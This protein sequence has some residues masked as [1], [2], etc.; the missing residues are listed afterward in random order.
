MPTPPFV[1]IQVQIN[2]G[3]QQSGGLTVAHS[4][5]VDVSITNT[6]GI[7]KVRY[8]IYD[9]PAGFGTPSGW[10]LDGTTGIIYV[11][12][13]GGAAPQFSMP[14]STTLWGDYMIRG[15]GN[16]GDGRGS[17]P[18]A[19]LTDEATALRIVSPSGLKD[20]AFKATNQFD[21][22]REWIGAFKDDLR[23]MEALLVGGSGQYKTSVKL[24]TTVNITLSGEQ[25]LDGTL[26]STSRV[27]VKDQST[28][29]QNGLYT[30]S[31]GAWT[32]T[33]DADEDSEVIAG[34]L[35]HVSEGS[36][37]NE[38]WWFVTSN[39]PI[40]V[41]TDPIVFAEI[42]TVANIGW[43]ETLAVTST[44]GGLGN[45]PTI[46]NG[47]SLLFA[48]DNAAPLIKQSD[49]TSGAGVAMTIQAQTTTAIDV[50]GAD[51]VLEV[52]DTGGGTGVQGNVIFGV[53]GGT[54][55]ARISIGSAS[56]YGPGLVFN[57]NIVTDPVVWGGAVTSGDG[58]D[59]YIIG[60]QCDGTNT[61]GGNLIFEPG[62]DGGG[63]GKHGVMVM[64][65]G[66][67]T[68]FMGFID[69]VTG[70]A[71]T[72]IQIAQSTGD[73]RVGHP[74]KL[75]HRN[76][77]DSNDRNL[78]SVGETVNNEV[79]IGAA[80]GT[81]KMANTLICVGE[82][83]L[84]DSS[85]AWTRT[86]GPP[87]ISHDTQTQDGSPGGLFTIRAQNHSHGNSNDP[88]DLFLSGGN[89]TN[90]SNPGTTG[91]VII[92]SGTKVTAGVIG[93]V[94]FQHGGTDIVMVTANGLE[95]DSAHA[96]PVIFQTA[97]GSGTGAGMLVQAQDAGTGTGGALAVSSGTGVTNDGDVQIQVGGTDAFVF[98]GA[99]SWVNLIDH[100]LRIGTAADVSANGFPPSGAIRWG[101]NS[102]K[103]IW[104]KNTAGTGNVRALW[105]NNNTPVLGST[106]S[107]ENSGTQILSS[108]SVTVN[109]DEVVLGNTV[110]EFGTTPA[111]VGDMRV[112]HGF[113]MRGRNSGDG[114]N[115]GIIDWGNQSTDDLRFGDASVDTF[116]AGLTTNIQAG[117]STR[118]ALDG[119]T[120][121]IGDT[122]RLDNAT[123]LQGE[124]VAT[125]T[126]R[127]LI[128]LDASDVV[129]VGDANEGLALVG[130]SVN[131]VS[132]ALQFES[133]QAS[134]DFKQLAVASGAGQALTIGAQDTGDA[135]NG[136]N[137]VLTS[138]A[139]TGG[140]HGSVIVQV[141][142]A[143]VIECVTG[144]VEIAVVGIQFDQALSA[145]SLIQE[146]ST[147][148]HGEDL[149]IQAQGTSWVSG[150]GGDLILAGGGSAGNDPGDVY[151]KSST[152]VNWQSRYI[153]GARQIGVFGV[154]P[155]ARPSA[156][157]QTYSSAT[158]THAAFTASKLTDSSS[159]TAD[160]T[161]SPIPNINGSGATTAQ[162][163]LIDDNFA[164]VTTELNALWDD[165]ENLKQLVNS[166]IDD[167]QSLGWKQ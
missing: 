164:E 156:Y 121:D 119:S 167:D 157:T 35:V 18:N 44:S 21:S 36:A 151:L 104:A 161:V 64:Q 81:I 149:T 11:E 114:A 94:Q 165:V 47:D 107:S 111:T 118:I 12:T 150:D 13:T 34:M 65:D 98:V 125:G 49:R 80:G 24:A 85:L 162:E 126:W 23:V 31:S 153:S 8:E 53:D 68:P 50:N 166:M 154:T 25:T 129:V 73:V 133:T 117:G 115:R 42:P 155:V 60:G 26:T 128:V 59:L 56:P 140:T 86:G 99:S 7:W 43:D 101:T 74:W 83:D 113:L 91:A 4:D 88:G 66:G 19:Q 139:S 152:I 9:Y 27:L 106:S 95:F 89:I 77:S 92:S 39:D 75:Y 17:V 146:S 20:I 54:E 79:K 134:P 28:Q 136:G 123:A 144:A 96:A 2:S 132:T 14:A 135:S 76:S 100:A 46:S 159:G 110:L 109:A 57:P 38:S 3:G 30:T 33:T 52:G 41:G 90:A 16:N 138:G 158:R 124:I 69:P 147:T 103:T 67:G 148:A 22:Q 32:R 127:D 105:V 131:I 116:L 15:I 142:G 55:I 71:S 72:T 61:T 145:P 48:N 120:V 37:Q 5:T 58:K 163:N 160:G 112:F 70:D 63:T 108:S 29:S 45:N 102:E 87:I 40:A 78:I 1:T 82:V 141:G 62:N 130:S 51:L 93:N 143:R 122:V 10:T 6:T 137:L 97:L 84:Q